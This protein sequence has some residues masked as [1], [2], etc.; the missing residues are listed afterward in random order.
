MLNKDEIVKLLLE[1]KNIFTAFANPCQRKR[2]L[3]SGLFTLPR[4][5]RGK[6]DICSIFGLAIK[7]NINLSIF[8]IS[9]FFVVF[10]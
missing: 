8:E 2:A 7:Q 1:R 9:D 10:S 3:D 6:K 4:D 5:L